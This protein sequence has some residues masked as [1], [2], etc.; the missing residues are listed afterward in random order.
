P[1]PPARC[2]VSFDVTATGR[3]DLIGLLKT[4]TER[5]RFLTGG[6]MPANL[7][8]V[9]PPS[10]SGTLGPDIPADGLTVTVGLG[11]SLFDAR[12]GIADRKP[13]HLSEMTSFPND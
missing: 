12:F 6:G 4:L 5:A 2:F 7:G 3:G 10:D 9:A 11:A 1:P 8:P 13:V